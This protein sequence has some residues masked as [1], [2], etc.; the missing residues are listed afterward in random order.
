[1]SRRD[2]PPLQ[3]VTD[4][5]IEDFFK[6]EE[7]RMGKGKGED[8]W[9]EA[10]QEYAAVTGKGIPEDG[11]P[12]EGE[13][14]EVASG[15]HNK[16]ASTEEMRDWHAAKMTAALMWLGVICI[17]ALVLAGLIKAMGWILGL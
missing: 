13:Y 1:M 14:L 5:N 9:H 2:R 8:P 17:M 11:D 3:R 7:I 6:T 16:Y 4:A 12:H 15:P 10:T